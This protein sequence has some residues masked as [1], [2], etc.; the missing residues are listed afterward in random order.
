MKETVLER[1][2]Y[3]FL[4]VDV[5]APTRHELDALAEAYSLHKTSVEDC[6]EASHLPKFEQIETV[7]FVIARAFDAGSRPDAASVQELTRKLA[8][9]IGEG[10]LI[11]VHRAGNSAID[12]VKDR[13]RAGV[14]SGEQPLAHVVNDL[15]RVVIESYEK[16]L[17]DCEEKLGVIE[18]GAFSPAA[19]KFASRD[20]YYLLRRA[21]VIERMLRANVEVVNRCP[22]IAEAAKPY[23]QD[24]REQGER[25]VLTARDVGESVQNVISISV[26]IA[27]QR[28]NEVMR[29]LTV[30]SVFFLPL[31]FLAGLY[32]MNFVK[33]PFLSAEH[34]FSV[35]VGLMSVISAG[36]FLW[37]RGRRWL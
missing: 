4:W 34:G 31:N 21:L 16:P 25:L 8:F 7:A 13:W 30:F 23:F 11:T 28:T 35:M 17:D 24:L 12:G 1:E 5:T 15:L 22:R 37:F 6:M 9:F 32:G 19:G 10:F 26:S 2:R 20:S 14:K 36:I 18:E 3:G 29:V 27:D 33:M